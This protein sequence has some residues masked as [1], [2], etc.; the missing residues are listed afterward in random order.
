M[1][2]KLIALDMDGT[3]LNSQHQLSP[4]NEGA[5]REAWAQ[6]VQIAFA[7]G[8]TQHSAVPIIRKLGLTTPGVYVQGLV[9]ANAD[10]SVRYERTLD[11]ALAHE[12]AELATA[13]GCS[14][15]AYAGRRLLTNVRDEY[16]DVFLKYHEPETEAFGTWARVLETPVNKFIMVSTKARI[17]V[18]RPQ[19]EAAVHGRA[20]VVQALDYMLEVLPHGASKGDGVRRL[21]ADLAIDPSEMLA[22]GDGEND[23]E[24]LQ[25][26]GVGVA[27]GNG[28]LAAKEAADYLTGTNDEDGVAQAIERFVL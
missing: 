23:V 2:I 9:I 21:L 20:T 4:R 8:K 13:A 11:S 5:L 12:V 18:L 19:V 28:M 27:M 14:M 15:V 16:T 17:D 22:V 3:L 25:L 7:T 6:G 24:M 1:P 26:A 10:G